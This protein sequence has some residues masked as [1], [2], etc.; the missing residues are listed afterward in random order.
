MRC[1]RRPRAARNR[2]R[3]AGEGPTLLDVRKFRGLL[4]RPADGEVS[5]RFGTVVHPRFKTRVLRPCLDIDG[6]FSN[7]I[8]AIFDGRVL[9]SAWMV[10][11][12]G[13]VVSSARLA[14]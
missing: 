8:R 1:A 4:D 6:D 2:F 9:F 10:C 11:A 5:A 14:G 12:G 13:R 3:P 7:S